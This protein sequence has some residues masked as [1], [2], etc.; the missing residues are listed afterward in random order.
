MRNVSPVQEALA[1][2]VTPA[3][4]RGNGP[5]RSRCHAARHTSAG[6][7]PS[8]SVSPGI[9]TSTLQ[10]GSS[11]LLPLFEVPW[12]EYGE[13]TPLR[14]E[15]VAARC[16]SAVRARAVSTMPSVVIVLAIL[17][18]IEQLCSH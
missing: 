11:P 18:A 7:A 13:Q 15:G 1:S 2:P 9:V 16:A 5:L 12:L 4:W 3:R 10:R 14:G 17:G 6:Y 8:T